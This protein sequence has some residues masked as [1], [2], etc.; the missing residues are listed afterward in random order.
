MAPWY[1][2]PSARVKGAPRNILVARRSQPMN[3]PTFYRAFFVCWLILS[4]LL[5]MTLVFGPPNRGPQTLA[6]LLLCVG[7]LLLVSLYMAPATAVIS[8]LIAAVATKPLA[9]LPFSATAPRCSAC[10]YNLTG[11]TTGICPECGT[12]ATT[13]APPPTNRT[14]KRVTLIIL[15]LSMLLWLVT[16]LIPTY[17]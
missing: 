11:N 12:P 10:D 8:F 2:Y 16:C 15:A 3:R 4:L 9:G 1:C 13:P 6:D 17:Y 14:A 5:A 7:A